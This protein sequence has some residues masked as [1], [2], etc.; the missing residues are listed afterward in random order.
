MKMAK[1]S[2]RRA[3]MVDAILRPLKSDHIFRTLDYRSRSESYLKQYMHQPLLAALVELHRELTPTLSETTLREREEYRA[4]RED[5]RV[6]R[7]RRSCRQMCVL[8]EA[9][10]PC[11]SRSRWLAEGAG[12]FS[13]RR[14]NG[15][16]QPVARYLTEISWDGTRFAPGDD[17]EESL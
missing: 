3:G 12:T 11:P 13:S 4:L 7:G 6:A 5:Q 9:L 10:R 8:D 15:Q 16:D 17:V 1:K 2:T 14:C